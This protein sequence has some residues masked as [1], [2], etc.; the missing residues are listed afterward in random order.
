MARIGPL[1][2]PLLLFYSYGVCV[3]SKEL[4]LT[5]IELAPVPCNDKAVGKLSR[6]AM[7]YINEDRPDGYKFALNRVANVHLHAQQI[8]GNCNTTL[9]YTPEGYTYLYSYDCTLVPDP[10]EKL[11]QTCPTCP[12]LLPVESH[13]AVNTAR[14][15]LASY[16]RQFVRGADLGV[17]TITRASTKVR[18]R[19]Q[20]RSRK[21]AI[22]PS[23]VCIF[24][25]V[26]EKSSFVEYT[27]Q[28][29]PEGLTERGTCQQPT[30][31]SDTQ[32]AGFCV[33][34]V[35]GNMKLNPEVLVSCE[36]F[37][38]QNVD[39]LRPVQPQSHGPPA[40][41]ATPTFPST[42]LDSGNDP[43]QPVVTDPA[44][45]PAV[46]PPP[47]APTPIQPAP[48]DPSV[49]VHPSTSRS[50]SSSESA[51][52]LS[53]SSSEE[54]GGPVALRP[55]VNFRYLRRE[56]RKRQAHSPIFLSEFPSGFSPFRSCPG[57]SRYTT[58]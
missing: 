53:D 40:D 27:V 14:I 56:R 34:S 52:G 41:A 54:I 4:S 2:L 22:F 23:H 21:S 3:R 33:G 50:S 49:V 47:P 58:V 31:D 30:P 6:L 20:D 12:L 48:I 1:V 26:P 32:A 13:Q 55:P 10:P 17:K 25:A 8:S 24:Q 35:H 28:E 45:P 46:Q 44:G 9:L 7:T 5:P 16:R 39:F 38:V 51:E 36:M 57:P 43:L 29:C 11:Q 19:F 42:I 18:L 15:T 37:K